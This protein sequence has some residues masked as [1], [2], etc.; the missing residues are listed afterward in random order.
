MAE[1]EK[2][3]TDVTGKAGDKTVQDT[4]LAE[5]SAEELIRQT[6]LGETYA[7]EEEQVTEDGTAEETTKESPPEETEV[8]T[9]QDE[10]PKAG[11]TKGW[12]KT[13]QA[14]D[15]EIAN[16]RKQLTA[17]QEALTT[18]KKE[19]PGVK[20]KPEALPELDEF[21]DVADVVKHLN[22]TRRQ[23]AEYQTRVQ[24]AENVK[25]Y[26]DIL[27]LACKVPGVGEEK[28]ND[29]DT[30]LRKLFQERGYDDNRYPPAD[31]VEDAAF[32]VALEMA[33]EAKTEAATPPPKPKPGVKTPTGKG[34]QPTSTDVEIPD[35]PPE[36]VAAKMVA[37]MKKGAYKPPGWI[38]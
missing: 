24:D 10:V 32:R 4:P 23:L 17:A 34:A 20:G 12:D 1:T 38:S 35:G 8:A 11:E 15:Q 28:R 14:K 21:A 27:T 19:T 2:V 9:E 13:R 36:V 25:A 5:L 18:A 33:L 6:G 22:A 3:T 29:I 31:Q 7:P 30:E 37:A 26:N 16:L